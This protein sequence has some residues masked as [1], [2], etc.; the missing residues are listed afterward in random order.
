M[1]AVTAPKRD[2]LAGSHRQSVE[3]LAGPRTGRRAAWRESRL[4]VLAIGVLAVHGIDDSFLQPRPGTSA[5]S[6]R[7]PRSTSTA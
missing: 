7:D 5:G 3:I 6:R 2:D 4:F 1:T